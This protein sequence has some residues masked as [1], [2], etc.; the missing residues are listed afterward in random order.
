MQS[1][2]CPVS[3]KATA[4][5]SVVVVFATPPFWLAKAIT[6]ARLTGAPV[7]SSDSAFFASISRRLGAMISDGFRRPELLVLAILARSGG[8][9]WRPSLARVR[10]TAGRFLGFASGS[11]RVGFIL[12]RIPGSTVF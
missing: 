8:V 7:A 6:S 12:L 5:L 1:T 4:R 10:I 11:G 9:R 2:R 3:L